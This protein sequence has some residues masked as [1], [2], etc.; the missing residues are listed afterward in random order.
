[1]F[2][3]IGEG[4]LRLI[5]QSESLD[6]RP[7]QLEDRDR[8]VVACISGPIQHTADKENLTSAPRQTDSQKSNWSLGQHFLL[9]LWLQGLTNSDYQ[10]M[11]LKSRPDHL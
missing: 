7:A 5:S 9:G 8:L 11:G 6:N 1:M 4:T 10:D 2:V 3:I